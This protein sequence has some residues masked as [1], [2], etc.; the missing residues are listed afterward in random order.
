MELGGPCL[1]VILRLNQRLVFVRLLL[2]LLPAGGWE[3][4]KRV[5]CLS[6]CLSVPENYEGGKVTLA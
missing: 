1:L 5:V 2:F 4:Y 6:V 3:V